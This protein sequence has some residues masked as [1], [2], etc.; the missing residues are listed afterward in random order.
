MHTDPGLY[1]PESPDAVAPA[2][3]VQRWEALTFLHWRYP[4][5]VV[6]ALLPTGLEVDTFDGDAWVAVVPFRMVKVRPP[7]A[8]PVP[9]LTTFP[10]TNLRTYVRD[11]AGGTGVW[12]WTLDITRLAG[13]AVARTWFRVPYTWASMRMVAGPAGA[14]YHSVRRWPDRGPHLDVAVE[15][16]APV[17]ADALLQFLTNRWRAYT[18]RR[19]GS[20]AFGPVAHEPWPL[21]EATAANLSESL[22]TAVGL[23]APIGPPLVH[24]SP[25]VSARVGSLRSVAPPHR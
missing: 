3:V 12:F 20:I 13:V 18:T 24:Y 7:W 5:E 16:G 19:D 17:R 21:F 23:P 22:T 25:G 6:Q 11:G 1:P 9:W 15:V 10:E 2:A 4:P 14:G 8:P